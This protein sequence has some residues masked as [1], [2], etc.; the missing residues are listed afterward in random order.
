MHESKP[1]K[2]HIVEFFIINNL[3]NI[4]VKVEDE[5][6]VNQLLRSMRSRSICSKGTKLTTS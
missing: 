2:S 3:D 6:Q 1:I 5:T 4:E